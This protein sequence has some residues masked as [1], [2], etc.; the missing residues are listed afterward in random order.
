MSLFCDYIEYRVLNDSIKI[1]NS[2]DNDVRNIWKERNKYVKQ[3]MHYK[4]CNLPIDIY[5][6]S[7]ELYTVRKDFSILILP[8]DQVIAKYDYGV[9]EGKPRICKEKFIMIYYGYYVYGAAGVAMLCA[10]ALSIICLLL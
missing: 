2:S 10:L 3:W 5:I 8:T 1:C 6:I 9:F 4:S 7:Q